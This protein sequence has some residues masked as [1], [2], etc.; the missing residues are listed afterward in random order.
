M[1]GNGDARLVSAEAVAALQQCVADKMAALQAI[2]QKVT[3]AHACVHAI[4]L[5]LEE[6]QAS[7]ATLGPKAAAV[8]L[9]PASTTAFFSSA[10]LPHPLGVT[11]PKSP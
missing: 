3:E 6:E 1:A 8:A 2:E 9:Q 7:A 4:A 5:L 10:P 11:P